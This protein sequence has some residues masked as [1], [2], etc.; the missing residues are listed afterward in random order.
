MILISLFLNFVIDFGLFFFALFCVSRSRFVKLL[1]DKIMSTKSGDCVIDYVDDHPNSPDSGVVSHHGDDETMSIGLASSA[2]NSP[3][4]FG[5]FYHTGMNHNSRTNS[6][7][8][9]SNGDD[10]SQLSF[11]DSGAASEDS[12]SVASSSGHVQ[13]IKFHCKWKGCQWPG[14]VDDL[15]DHIVEHLPKRTEDHNNNEDC[16]TNEFVCKWLGCKVFGVPFKKSQ[17]LQDHCV[18]RHCGDNPFK[19]IVDGCGA[20]FKSIKLRQKHVDD[21][22]RA[23]G[24]FKKSNLLTKGQRTISS[25]ASTDSVISYL[26]SSTISAIS[27]TSQ[28]FSSTHTTTLTSRFIGSSSSSTSSDVS[29]LS[30]RNDK[31]RKPCSGTGENCCCTCQC[32][33]CYICTQECFTLGRWKESVEHTVACCNKPICKKILYKKKRKN[34]GKFLTFFSLRYLQIFNFCHFF[35]QQINIKLFHMIFVLVKLINFSLENVT[36]HLPVLKLRML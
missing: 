35:L 7:T 17:T 20:R 30:R 32:H 3:V 28:L 24:K 26:S 16:E 29:G 15:V 34:T 10:E 6:G 33:S 1:N 22:F 14:S 27:N 4:K 19:C 13:N 5:V 18:G 11:A 21:H 12:L 36:S 25:S 31:F 9:N 2:S 23:N 8:T